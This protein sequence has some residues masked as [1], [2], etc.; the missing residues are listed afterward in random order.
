MNISN[1]GRG[2]GVRLFGTWRSLHWRPGPIAS[3]VPPARAFACRRHVPLP[4]PGT[5]PAAGSSH[6]ALA[7]VG[8][9]SHKGMVQ[10][11]PNP[12]IWVQE[13][14]QMPELILSQETFLRLAHLLLD[15]I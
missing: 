1:A 8:V 12:R 2:A 10:L 4:T 15:L 13:Q 6:P 3:P 5:A 11:W 14:T 7:S 9:W